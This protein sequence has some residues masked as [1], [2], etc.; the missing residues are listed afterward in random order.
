MLSIRHK[1]KGHKLHLMECLFYAP[2]FCFVQ[3]VR[4]RGKDIL[5]A[6]ECLEKPVLIF[7]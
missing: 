7:S 3:T 2:A 6:N 4:V 1:T 5:Q